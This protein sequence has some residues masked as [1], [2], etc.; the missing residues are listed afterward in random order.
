MCLCRDTHTRDGGTFSCEVVVLVLT[1]WIYLY[2][3]STVQRSRYLTQARYLGTALVL[4]HTSFPRTHTR[5]TAHAVTRVRGYCVDKPPT[6][7]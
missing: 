5:C 7:H 6:R 2:P 3:A 4:C 1:V